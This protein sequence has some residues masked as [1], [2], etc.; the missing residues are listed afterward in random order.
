MFQNELLARG[1]PSGA[2]VKNLSAMQENQVLS[3]SQEDPLATEMATHS[4]ILTWEVPWTE[5]PGGYIS[6]RCCKQL[7]T[8]QGQNNQNKQKKG[9]KNVLFPR[10]INSSHP[11]QDNVVEIIISLPIFK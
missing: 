5:E 11:F 2:A 6:P 1:F 9:Y 8:T 3:L 7:D 10:V 4:S